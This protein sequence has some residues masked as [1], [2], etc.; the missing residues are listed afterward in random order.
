MPSSDD[1]NSTFGDWWGLLFMVQLGLVL[2]VV[3]Y[4]LRLP[5]GFLS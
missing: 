2:V 1:I 5:S 4:G 3:L